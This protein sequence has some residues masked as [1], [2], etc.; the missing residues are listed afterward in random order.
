MKNKIIILLFIF[1]NYNSTAKT[2]LFPKDSTTYQT[3]E[4]G[5]SYGFLSWEQ[6]ILLFGDFLGVAF[7]DSWFLTEKSSIDYKLRAPAALH[8]KYYIK[9]SIAINTDVFYSYFQATKTFDITPNENNY[10]ST[11]HAYGMLF[12]ASFYYFRRKNVQVYSGADV[13]FFINREIFKTVSKTEKRNDGFFAF[14]LNAV[15]A[16]FGNK[17]GGHIELGYGSKGIVNFGLSYKF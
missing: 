12:G 2:K 14:Q 8:Y 1:I 4:I 5:I 7:F 15:G 16:R 13:G 6:S 10:T 9:P 11:N 3:H 17:F